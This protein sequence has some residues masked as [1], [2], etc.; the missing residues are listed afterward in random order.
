MVEGRGALYSFTRGCPVGSLRVELPGAEALSSI[1][2]DWA[3]LL[4]Q[5]RKVEFGKRGEGETNNSNLV[6]A[7]IFKV[8]T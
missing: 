5:R 1:V 3:H 6:Y 8:E 2:F 4:M 7:F